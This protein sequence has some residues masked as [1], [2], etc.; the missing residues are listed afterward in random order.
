MAPA[1]AP[2]SATLV[3]LAV[4][5]LSALLLLP[6]SLVSVLAGAPGKGV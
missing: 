4:R 5:S 1:S 2:L 3:F 6:R